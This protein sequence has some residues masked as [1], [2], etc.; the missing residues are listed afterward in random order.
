[1]HIMVYVPRCSYNSEEAKRYAD[2]ERIDRIQ[3][4]HSQA[5]VVG[6]AISSS[7]VHSSLPSSSSSSSSSY[8]TADT[9]FDAI[10]GDQRDLRTA[11]WFAIL[12]ELIATIVRD[13][14]FCPSY[15]IESL[16]AWLYECPELRGVGFFPQRII[17]RVDK[18]TVV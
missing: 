7:A 17:L 5:L 10:T 15:P 1:M 12:A 6:R 3:L 8:R 9:V 16:N 13:Y 2:E 14:K 11:I 4:D 18:N